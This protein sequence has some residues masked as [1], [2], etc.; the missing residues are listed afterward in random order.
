MSKEYKGGIIRFLIGVSKDK[1]GCRRSKE[2]SYHHF[3]IHL[4]R[5][6][7][8]TLLSLSLLTSSFFLSLVLSSSLHN[9]LSLPLS[10]S[11]SLSFSKII[12][13]NRMK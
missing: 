2:S 6:T 12:E 9:Y 1:V 3:Q 4:L 11:L 5:I 7:V 10:L 8:F 13:Q